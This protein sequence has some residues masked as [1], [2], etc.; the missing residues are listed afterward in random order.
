MNI[1]DLSDRFGTDQLP[2]SLNMF[3]LFSTI[4]MPVKVEFM[5]IGRDGNIRSLVQV[6]L[7]T[8]Q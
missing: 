2:Y 3:N 6:K 8:S 1:K 7:Y 4:C 5:N